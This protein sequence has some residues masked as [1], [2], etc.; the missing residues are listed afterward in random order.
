MKQNPKRPTAYIT[1]PIL[2]LIPNPLESIKLP[3][4]KFMIGFI[5]K[6]TW[7]GRLAYVSD[8]SYSLEILLDIG[9]IALF[10]RLFIQKATLTN[11]MITHR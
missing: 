2:K 5:K 10:A 1:A 7:I 4:V 9:I 6:D 3:T 8:R 11:T